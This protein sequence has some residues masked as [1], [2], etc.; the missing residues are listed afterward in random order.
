MLKLH[1]QLSKTIERR[2]LRQFMEAIIF[3]GL[4]DYAKSAER[5]EDPLLHFTIFGNRRTYC[6]EGKIT[7]FD[8]VRL[9]EGSIRSVHPDGSRTET[10]IE[11]LAEDLIADPEKGISS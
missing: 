4:M 7:S 1:P 6:C 9:I 3:E 8:R 5:P 10:V 11:E 2:V